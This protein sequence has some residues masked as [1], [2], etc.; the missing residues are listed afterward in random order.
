MAFPTNRDE[1]KKYCL[2]NLGYGA[3]KINVT[4][5]QVDDRIDEA[6]QYYWDYHFDGTEKMY[7]KHQ[8]TQ[9]DTVNKYITMPDNIIGV[10]NLFS[11]GQGLSSYDMFSIQYQI[12]L[13]DLYNLASVSLVPYYMARQHLNVMEEILVGKQPIRYNR[14]RNQL[15]LD[16]DWSKVNIGQYIVVEAYQI[17]DPATF[18]EVWK[19]RWLLRYATALIKKQWGT[20]MKKFIGMKLPGDIQF[21]GQQLYEEAVEEIAQMEQEMITSFSLPVTDLVG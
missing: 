21:N 8:I 11:I 10:V 19:D 4:D 1:F 13:N 2:R 3:T 5:E 9:Q 20:N 12:A 18:T 16:M 17:V 15:W 7:Y 14:H 6:L